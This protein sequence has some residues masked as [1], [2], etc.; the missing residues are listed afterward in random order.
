MKGGDAGEIQVERIDY[1]VCILLVLP[2][3]W[4][5]FFTIMMFLRGGGGEGS[6]TGVGENRFVCFVVFVFPPLIC[7]MPDS[8]YQHSA[9][10]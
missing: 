3:F 10:I 2:S 9:S 8:H 6:M 4:F 1:D 7:L 5:I